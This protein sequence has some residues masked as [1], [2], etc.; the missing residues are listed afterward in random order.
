MV[1]H[2]APGLDE[3]VPPGL[4]EDVVDLRFELGEKSRMAEAELVL[5][6][7][8]LHAQLLLLFRNTFLAKWLSTELSQKSIR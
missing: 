4:D 8:L 3:D 6:A 7:T 2:R 5:V 1:C